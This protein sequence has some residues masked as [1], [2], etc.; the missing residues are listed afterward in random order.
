VSNYSEVLAGFHFVDA[1]RKVMRAGDFVG[2][3]Q[4]LAELFERVFRNV[5]FVGTIHCSTIEQAEVVLPV[6][7]AFVEKLNDRGAELRQEVSTRLNFSVVA[8]LFLERQVTSSTVAVVAPC[9]PFPTE[10][11]P[12]AFRILEKLLSTE[13]WTSLRESQGAYTVDVMYQEF[14]CLFSIATTCDPHPE[15]TEEVVMRTVKE[16]AEGKIDEAALNNAVVRCFAEIDRPQ[17]P[18]CK[19]WEP[20]CRGWS[21]EWMQSRRELMYDM[22]IEKVVAAAVYPTEVEWHCCVVSNRTVAE[23]PE[24][25]VFLKEGEEANAGAEE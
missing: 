19:G 4:K 20:F 17:E 12:M 2:Q 15:L 21:R 16:I 3:G 6:F 9:G 25:F 14:E 18:Q 11:L 24:G 22:T 5:S 10:D 8:K 1:L 13:L 7:R 23:V